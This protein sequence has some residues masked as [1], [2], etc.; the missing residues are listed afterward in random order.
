M[1]HRPRFLILLPRR[2]PREVAPPWL[3][4]HTSVYP[5]ALSVEEEQAL[6]ALFDVELDAL[7]ATGAS[8]RVRQVR[9]AHAE[10][11]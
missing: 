9:H 7:A 6:R 2:D 8:C 5:V 1:A 3:Q 4:H 10:R 11:N